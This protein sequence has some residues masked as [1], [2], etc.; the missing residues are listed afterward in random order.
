MNA[1]LIKNIRIMA[2]LRAINQ[3]DNGKIPIFGY[4]HSIIIAHITLLPSPPN[5]GA[6]LVPTLK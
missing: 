3:L 1:K 6:G 5:A 2:S 4:R